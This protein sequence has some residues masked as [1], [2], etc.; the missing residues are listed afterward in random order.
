MLWFGVAVSNDTKVHSKSYFCSKQMHQLGTPDLLTAPQLGGYYTIS[1]CE[2]QRL[3][4]LNSS[5]RAKTSPK[6]FWYQWI[7]IIYMVS[8]KQT[9][10]PLP[11]K[12]LISCFP[13]FSYWLF[14]IRCPRIRILSRFLSTSWLKLSSYSSIQIS[15]KCPGDLPVLFQHLEK[16]PMQDPE[17]ILM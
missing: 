16:V 12:K 17:Y 7:K 10:L 1:S 15:D 4:Y 5:H 11:C 14:I 8:L 9:R 3:Y 2:T 6:P 13:S